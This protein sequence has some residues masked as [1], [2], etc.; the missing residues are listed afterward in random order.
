[1]GKGS[2]SEREDAHDTQH[3]VKNDEIYGRRRTPEGK[4]KISNELGL[5]DTEA[6]PKRGNS[7]L[8]EG[9]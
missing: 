9:S 1:M 4:L 5:V 8:Y 2:Q 6:R 7:T 3:R